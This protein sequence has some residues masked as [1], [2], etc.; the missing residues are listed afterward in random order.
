M[1]KISISNCYEDSQDCFFK[2]IVYY[3]LSFICSSKANVQCMWKRKLC[4]E[5][6]YL[7]CLI[8]KSTYIAKLF[9]ITSAHE[10]VLTK[11]PESKNVYFN[12]NTHTHMH[13]KY[14][15]IFSSLLL[16]ML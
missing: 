10:N 9:A 4:S 5:S 16:N 14:I 13:V 1:F 6:P 2:H 3:I 15:A 8:V 11:I 7:L 12:K